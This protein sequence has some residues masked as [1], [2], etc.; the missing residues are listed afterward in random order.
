MKIYTRTGDDGTTGLLFGARVSKADARV[1][2]Y[3]TVDEANA[4]LGLA[5]AAGLAS[6]VEAAVARAQSVL[7]D[8]GASLADA[9][10]VAAPPGAAAPDPV[11][12]EDD[13]LAL[14][15]GIDALEADL[16]PLR[17][18]V[19]PAGAEAAARLHVAR[20]VVRRAER[21][22]V[23]LAARVPVDPSVVRYLNRL[24][25]YLFVAARAANR[26]AGVDDVPWVARKARRPS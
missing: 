1:E 18:F 10:P 3:G 8:V 7:F 16:A 23:G 15:R 24:S 26:A 5:R 13:V 2:A 11:V 4:A 25:D 9:R 22:V 20:T 21:A 17:T 6:P 12:A 14:E 19:L